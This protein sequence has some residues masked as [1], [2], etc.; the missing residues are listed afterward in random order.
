MTRD[1]P[2]LLSFSF[3][4]AFFLFVPPV[5]P[6]TSSFS[7]PSRHFWF[8]TIFFLQYQVHV[9]SCRCLLCCKHGCLWY[10]KNISYTKYNHTVH[11][12]LILLHSVHIHNIITINTFKNFHLLLR[13][14]LFILPFFTIS[15][16]LFSSFII[17]VSWNQSLV[18][19]NEKEDPF[20]LIHDKSYKQ[21]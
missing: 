18:S 13:F 2:R 21:S 17:L 20:F 1:D 15:I 14:Y 10:S 9:P 8:E 11:Y 19:P 6:P 5:A 3:T 12:S 7:T 16:L 4:A